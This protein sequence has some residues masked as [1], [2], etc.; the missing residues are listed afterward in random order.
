MKSIFAL[1]L[2]TISFATAALAENLD[3]DLEVNGMVCA[4]CAYN[5]SKQLESIDGVAPG[6]VDVDLEHGRVTLQ[7]K[8][9]LD[10]TE[11]AD[12]LLQAGFKLGEVNK[13]ASFVRQ[14]RQ[15]ADRDVLLS[16]TMNSAGISNGELD[17]VLEALGAFAVAQSGQ[18]AIA[19]PG[20]LETAILKPVLG[21]RRT[22]IKVDYD[23]TSESD[24]TV[25][26][27]VLARPIE[28]R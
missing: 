27:S 18:I 17:Q 6:S 21:G 16:V 7:A 24:K 1:V 9:E 22:V 12:L 23:Q 15:Y 2:L 14:P 20:E 5:V 3:Y 13:S 10:K 25:A 26:V 4:F 19:G 28:T 11:I 8:N